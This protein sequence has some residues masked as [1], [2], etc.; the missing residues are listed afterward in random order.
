MSLQTA[1]IRI[2][3]GFLVYVVLAI[4]LM[5]AMMAFSLSSFRRGA[6]EQLSRTVDA[7][8][9]LLVA[10]A[11]NQ[12]VMAT[13]K[14]R[15]NDP[16]TAIGQA[17]REV[18]TI[19]NPL[20]S[21]F[22]SKTLT[23]G[24]GD[25]PVTQ[26]IAG[27]IRNLTVVPEARVQIVVTARANTFATSAIGYIEVI[28]RAA[29]TGNLTQ[30]LEIKERREL[31]LANITD[32]LDKYALFVKSY[33]PD[34]NDP[35][36]RIV[37]QGVPNPS[38]NRKVFSWVYLGNRYYP[39]CAEFAGGN[40]ASA[41]ILLD[42]DFVGDR[43]LVSAFAMD[44]DNAV[45]TPDFD[46]DN[47][48]KTSKGQL[49][50]VSPTGGIPFL[51]I[52]RPT[53]PGDPSVFQESDFYSVPELRKY[54]E[55]ILVKPALAD[56]NSGN[57]N[58]TSQAIA[59]DYNA[60]RDNYPGSQAFRALVK[61]CVEQWRYYFGYTDY[62]HLVKSITASPIE[63]SQFV[64]TM[65]F[66][67]ILNYFVSYKDYNPQR[68]MGGKMPAFFGPDRKTPVMIEGNCFLRYFKV[69]FFDQVVPQLP[70]LASI[71]PRKVI[72][73][74]IALKYSW[75]GGGTNFLN[76]MV[77]KIHGNEKCLM[78]RAV[79]GFSINKFF[80]P[81][82]P[83]HSQPKQSSGSGGQKGDEI[84]PSFDRKLVT[85]QFDNGGQLLAKRVYSD[86]QG[87]RVLD[88]DGWMVV[89]GGDLDL[90]SVGTFRGRGV[91]LVLGG[92]VKLGTL[93]K[94]VPGSSDLL[95]IY[96]N[97][98]NIEIDSTSKSD[99]VR[100][101]ASLI[102]TC[103]L[104]P[105]PQGLFFANRKNVEIK[106]NLVADF[107]PIGDKSGKGLGGTLKIEHDTLLYAPTDPYRVSL[108][109]VRT[110]YSVNSGKPSW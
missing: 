99:P 46:T 93:V 82:E 94:L 65:P 35:D 39:P 71:D 69:A 28:S 89:Y 56:A 109:A 31:K 2:R 105:N 9:L 14:R 102:T 96:V 40:V 100:I 98:G 91:I 50:W 107:L 36:H 87:R 29:P 34:Y 108:G 75:G 10:Q 58:A 4:L 86:E 85:Y 78:S 37:I 25:L 101:E 1:P 97:K 70:I 106:G 84:F 6:V 13:L 32:F 110:L 51:P 45:F 19:Q 27:T 64:Q 49:F 54:Y 55:E 23:F 60:N 77:A 67:G 7:N 59:D 42:L 74:P 21:G 41:P 5:G 72:L 8:R 66:E 92:N 95:K 43:N 81:N 79:D 44:P 80:F 68:L 17:F 53:N 16:N 63:L 83:D 22:W 103:M 47:L 90:T 3:S 18:F 15:A 30:S 62:S 20:A 88:I 48:K 61:T 73:P 76:R 12:E 52:T 57:P 11:A 26:G 33:V 38:G 104:A 24:S